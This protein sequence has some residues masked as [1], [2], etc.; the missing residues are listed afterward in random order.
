MLVYIGHSGVVC[1]HNHLIAHAIVQSQQYRHAFID[2]PNAEYLTF[3]N[4]PAFRYKHPVGLTDQYQC[5]VNIALAQAS[6]Q[7][8]GVVE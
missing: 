3:F 7:S 8:Q 2:G 6:Y 4:I 1:A 5:L